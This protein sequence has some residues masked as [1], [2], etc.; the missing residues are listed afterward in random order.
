MKS[1]KVFVNA[2]LR[3][4][5]IS[6]LLPILLVMI[7]FFVFAPATVY[8]ADGG[9]DDSYDRVSDAAELM[10][11]GECA[12]L[13]SK[14]NEIRIRQSFD[15]AVVTTNGI[16]DT[17]MAEYA[18]TYYEL[19]SFGYG[20]EGDGVL[21]LINMETHDWYIASHGYGITAFTDAGIEYIGNKISPYL[22][23]GDYAEGFLKF[24]ELCD[25]FITQARSGS[26]YDNSNLP[27]E[28]LSLIWIPLSLLIGLVIAS[29]AVSSMKSKLKTVRAATKAN[30]YVKED[31]IN[32]TDCRDMFLYR[33][34]TREAKAQNNK[35]SGDGGSTTHQSSSGSTYGGG[36]GKF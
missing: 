28:P 10:S 12:E 11:E 9:F 35:N 22:S 29:I 6:K 27:R 7:S 5:A 26:P 25:D 8:A 14:I 3:M 30:S 13:A 16:G 19:S 18:D 2:A 4:K 34:V 1:T 23:E 33:K 20:S 21:L 15:I 17:T 32:L 24:A 36:G 31:S